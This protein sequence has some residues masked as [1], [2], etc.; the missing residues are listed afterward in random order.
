[1]KTLIATALLTACCFSASATDSDQMNADTILAPF[2]QAVREEIDPWKDSRDMT[3]TTMQAAKL[4]D[5]YVLG[6]EKKLHEL[7]LAEL[8][9]L[10]K[11]DYDL[12]D[13]EVRFESKLD[14]AT[15]L[16][17]PGSPVSSGMLVYQFW[18][19]KQAAHQFKMLAL[20]REVQGQAIG[21]HVL[22]DRLAP[23]ETFLVENEPLRPLLAIESGNDV[24]LVKLEYD[25]RGFYKL[26]SI[27]FAKKKG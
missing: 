4:A 26:T 21:L 5:K 22:R 20:S 13:Y 2:Y 12:E 7:A 1:M 24:C 11:R 19:P 15:L 3:A 27:R 10:P 6:H 14:F 16:S 18:N 8:K 25:D 17:S 9:K 23:P